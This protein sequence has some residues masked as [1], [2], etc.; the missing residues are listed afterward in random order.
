MHSSFYKR[1]NTLLADIQNG[2]MGLCGGGI[3]SGIISSPHKLKFN[4]DDIVLDLQ[5][6]ISAELL[7][8]W[9][10]SSFDRKI[11]NGQ[12]QLQMFAQKLVD[13]L[14]PTE[15]FYVQPYTFTCIYDRLP[16]KPKHTSREDRLEKWL[17]LILKTRC[18][19][20]NVVF[21]D[22]SHT[23]QC[24]SSTDVTYCLFDADETF[25][26]TPVTEGARLFLKFKVYSEQLDT[27][28]PQIQIT[29]QPT[30]FDS[31]QLTTALKSFN[32]ENVLISSRNADLLVKFCQTMAINA[33]KVYG[34]TDTESLQ[35]VVDRVCEPQDI[36]PFMHVSSFYDLETLSRS[37]VIK[38]TPSTH[39]VVD[40][41]DT[42]MFEHH[43]WSG[44]CGHFDV[45]SKCTVGYVAYT[46]LNP[47]ENFPFST[48]S[49]VSS[50]NILLYLNQYSDEELFE[51]ENRK[52]I[53]KL[54]MNRVSFSKVYSTERRNITYVY[55]RLLKDG[56][57]DKCSI[58]KVSYA[59]DGY[60]L[61]NLFID[62]EDDERVYFKVDEGDV[63]YPFLMVNT[64]IRLGNRLESIDCTDCNSI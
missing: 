7:S 27:T 44:Y 41:I 16:T 61:Q 22:I 62:C 21:T 14:C 1:A 29:E 35:Y 20:G 56:R 32:Q 50:K 60:T 55:S 64:Q 37:K 15:N 34:G 46:L 39:F 25:D 5:E 9:P 58:L 52:Y 17:I 12:L 4:I 23:L 33:I 6:Y 45:D 40:G 48:L 53:A 63:V 11:N 49:V 30:T 31:R 2:L 18:T 54:K 3:K 8:I 59:V 24:K 38:Y 28:Y 42:K 36:D 13:K 26:L 10:L 47:N 19:G 51:Y 57:V 43:A